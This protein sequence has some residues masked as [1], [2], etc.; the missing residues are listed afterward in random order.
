MKHNYTWLGHVIHFDGDP[1][2]DEGVSMV[3]LTAS[4]P[5]VVFK[6][7]C[8]MQANNVLVMTFDT[9]RIARLT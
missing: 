2:S 5:E 8:F 9:T 4:V 1:D 6:A 3:C 7:L